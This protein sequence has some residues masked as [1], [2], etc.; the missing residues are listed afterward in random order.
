MIKGYSVLLSSVLIFYSCSQGHP[1][2][3]NVQKEI[4]EAFVSNESEAEEG[5]AF[6]EKGNVSFQN[7]F[8][9]ENIIDWTIEY[10][11]YACTSCQ[12]L[13]YQKNVNQC[14]TDFLGVEK[15]KG[16][17]NR[18]FFERILKN[19]DAEQRQMNLDMEYPMAYDMNATLSIEE[20]ENRVQLY[21]QQ[22][23]FL[24]GA[25]GQT[26]VKYVQ[27]DKLTG[28]TLSLNDFI[29]DKTKLNKLCEPYFRRQNELPKTGSLMDH[30]F[31]VEFSCNDNFYFE[32]DSLYFFYNQYEIANYSMGV[33]EFG[34]P[35][36]ALTS[37]LKRKP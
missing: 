3:K 5:S 33:F 2:E 12:L 7:K 11:F 24:G 29:S 6:I 9:A 8:D 27:V 16:E 19:L 30:G 36:S 4:I 26:E 23:T 10:N 21:L 1:K 25:H 22:Y 15:Y 20:N 34:V 37:I 18:S 31:D 17:L 13:P 32:K 28:K 14:I 35:L